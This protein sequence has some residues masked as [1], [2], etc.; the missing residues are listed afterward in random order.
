M[1]ITSSSTEDSD[2]AGEGGLAGAEEVDSR[3]LLMDF[4]FLYVLMVLILDSAILAALRCGTNG[5]NT[6]AGF[7]IARL[8]PMVLET[9][10]AEREGI[11]R[12]TSY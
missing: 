1:R 7:V 9:C 8:Y 4:R 10:A 3:E 2:D 12:A 11:T 6:S 5:N